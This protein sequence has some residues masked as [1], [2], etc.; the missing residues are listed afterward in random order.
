M[1][2]IG[3]H[4]KM[5]APDYVLGS[6]NE[7]LSYDATALMLYTGAPQNSKRVPIGQLKIDEA[8]KTWTDKGYQLD[9][10]VIHAPYLINLAN[11]VKQET[12]D[13][14]LE[15][16]QNEI[17]RVAAIG[18]KYLVLHP[19]STVGA[20]HDVALNSIVNGLNSMD[21]HGVTICLETMAGK[22]SETGYLFSQIQTIIEA[23][24]LDLAVC[25][26]TCHIHDAG[27]DLSKPDEVL[28][29]FDRVIGL[30]KL[31]VI[32]VNDSKNVRG[33]RKDRHANIGEGEIGYQNIY[34]FVHHPLL[35]NKIFIL[36]T[37]YK[38]DKPPYKE[39][40]EMLRATL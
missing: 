16:L 28:A 38:D 34:N 23:S 22:G 3:S 20:P 29:E 40:I 13:A 2:K 27:Y 17:D 30:D 18:G 9:S 36:E 14:S 26:D 37:P 4:V 35:E 24:D 12:F 39:E 11:T 6:V 1:L 19:G 32:H 8:V 21:T 7:A 31:K 10:V 5:N 33:S 25:L 15:I